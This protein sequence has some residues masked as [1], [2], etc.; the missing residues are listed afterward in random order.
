MGSPMI[1]FGNAIRA[2]KNKLI[3][4]NDISIQS[5]ALNPTVTPVDAEPGSQYNSSLTSGVYIKQDSG[6]TTNWSLL[7]DTSNEIPS[8]GTTGQALIKD[9]SSN[10]DVEWGIPTTEGAIGIVI[11]GGG[12]AITTGS[13]GSI[14]IPYN[15]EILNWTLTA[16]IAGDIVIDV[17]KATYSGFPTTS[18]IAGSEKPTLSA[19]Q[20]NQDLT[21]TTWT[22]TVT[23]GDVLEF[24]VDSAATVTKV[25]LSIKVNKVQ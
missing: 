19:A 18:S 11:D 13:K 15:C 2:L 12:S 16:D 25:T 23:A 4:T 5:G 17:K 20:K 8:G 14:T 3:F 10:Y 9:S 7:D 24:V 22:T 1:W 21:L 6:S